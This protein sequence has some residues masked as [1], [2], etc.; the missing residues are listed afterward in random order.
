MTV[1]RRKAAHA[2]RGKA[3]L[4]PHDALVLLTA[5]YNEIDKLIREF[6]R[7][8]KAGDSVEKGKAALRICHAFELHAA[9]KHEV[10]YPAAEAVL[11]GMDKELLGKA[12]VEHDGIGHLIEKVEDTAAAD[13]S[14]DSRVAVLAEQ[15][16]RLMK[17]EEAELFPR[18]RHSRLDLVGIGERMAARKTE[19]S[20]APIDR[21]SIRQAR[22]VMGGVAG[23]RK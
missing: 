3:E 2:Q 21:E 13:P 20:T 15:A 16:G 14:F 23:A 9:I 1:A 19:L 12:R 18:L 22:K 7:L 4:N 5:G 17:K 10:F 8:R 6:E 11:E